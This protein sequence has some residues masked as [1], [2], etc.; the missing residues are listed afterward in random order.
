M[1]FYQVA[2]AVSG[3]VGALIGIISLLGYKRTEDLRAEIQAA[4]EAATKQPIPH[5][6]DALSS[7][8]PNGER[9]KIIKA[10]ER[11]EV[12]AEER[13]KEMLQAKSDIRI[14]RDI[15]REVLDRPGRAGI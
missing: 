11:L 4:K 14:I 3:T 2:T 15:L 12:E 13:R 8:F 1:E 5:S 6:E 9:L 7:L 10:I